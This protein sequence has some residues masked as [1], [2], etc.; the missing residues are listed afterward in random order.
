M[1]SNEIVTLIL[2]CN[3]SA[4]DIESELLNTGLMPYVYTHLDGVAW[5]TLQ[6]MINLNKRLVVFSDV[7][8]ASASQAWYH[9]VWDFAVETHYSVNNVNDFT[10]AYNRGDSLNDLYIFNHFVT[11]GVTGT[12]MDTESAIANE[13]N[14]L[15][16]RIELNN[17]LK[18]K[19][20][21]F[22]TV[23]FFE[24][25][26]ALDVVNTLNGGYLGLHHSIKNPEIVVEP[27]PASDFVQL[28]VPN[29]LGFEVLL[30]NLKGEIVFNKSCAVSSLKVNTANL[31]NGLYFLKIIQKEGVYLKKVVVL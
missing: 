17:L 5:P 14:F 10:D 21:N 2:E 16:N 30:F 28:H 19:F 25:G 18:G 4:D 15:L 24:L 8:D 31:P 9:Y 11:N 20:P 7:A 13:Y 1:N 22:I 27:N 6:E 12:G 3:V 29:E 26:N 23:D